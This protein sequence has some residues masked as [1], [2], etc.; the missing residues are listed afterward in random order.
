M[1]RSVIYCT[2]CGCPF[3]DPYYSDGMAGDFDVDILPPEQTKVWGDPPS[4][5]LISNTYS[6]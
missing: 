6:G 4:F 1:G 2:I 5:G 3:E